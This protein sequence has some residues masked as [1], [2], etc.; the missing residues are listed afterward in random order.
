MQLGR[1]APCTIRV[2]TAQRYEM[3]MQDFLCVPAFLAN[4]P[5]FTRASVLFLATGRI[6]CS[7]D[8]V[9]VI[10]KQKNQALCV[11]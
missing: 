3:L 1:W 7:E 5:A 11:Q 10:G 4:S 8:R 6:L 9:S 2:R